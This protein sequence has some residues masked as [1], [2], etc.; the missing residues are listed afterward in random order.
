MVWNNE[1]P[2]NLSPSL[3]ITPQQM[4]PASTADLENIRSKLRG[5]CTGTE[6]DK[7]HR[8]SLIK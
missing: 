3:G 4:A 5:W 1:A 2:W 8:K 7:L 6:G